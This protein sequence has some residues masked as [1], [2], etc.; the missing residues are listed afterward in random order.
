MAHG[1]ESN[2]DFVSLKL[3]A[4][5]G[6]GTIIET[7]MS[8]S[9]ALKLGGLDFEVGK[10]PNVHRI[11]LESGEPVEMISQDSFFTY[12]TDNNRV[13]GPN[14]GN[15]YTPLQ[16]SEAFGMIDEVVEKGNLVIE[17]AGSLWGGKTV[18]VCARQKN[19]IVVGKEDETYQYLVLS[20]SHDGSMAATAFFTGVRVVCNN[21]LNL[22][23]KNCINKKSIKHFKNVKHSYNEALKMI[24]VIETNH[25][26]A[27]DAYN[28]MAK[29]KLSQR[30][31][32]DYLGNVF[33]EPG[34]RK[35]IKTGEPVKEVISP[36]KTKLIESVIEYAHVGPGQ[37]L[38]GE[39]TSWWAYNAVAG[40]FDNVKEYK[41]PDR[42]M[43]RIVWNE[44]ANINAKALG[45]ALN[46]NSLETL[47]NPLAGFSLN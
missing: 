27:T 10:L 30:Q 41:S 19:P 4:W 37:E 31:F 3:G 44:D 45:L 13:L 11:P 47:S 7:E 26:N 22:S 39:M 42:R 16:N 15:Y 38:A 20:N 40:Y 17:T 18:F 8:V 29:I 24:G 32:F 12:R 28:Q 46:P 1:I 25:E 21:T 9:E 33:F 5:H 23:L 6:L 35:R 34:E 14:V 2:K 43:E 36:Q